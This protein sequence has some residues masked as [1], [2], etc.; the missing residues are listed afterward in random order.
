M[1]NTN[2]TILKLSQ[3][4]GRAENRARIITFRALIDVMVLRGLSIRVNRSDFRFTVL[5][6]YLFVNN[7]LPT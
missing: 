1:R 6:P 7:Y 5:E 4:I 2:N 3:S